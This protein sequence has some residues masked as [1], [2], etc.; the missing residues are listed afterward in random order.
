MLAANVMFDYIA[1]FAFVEALI[2]GSWPIALRA[3][4]EDSVPSAGQLLAV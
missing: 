3:K 4:I 2:V 1:A